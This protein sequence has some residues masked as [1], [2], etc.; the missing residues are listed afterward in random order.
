MVANI[1]VI[2]RY[3]PDKAS[4]LGPI[5][6]KVFPTLP[7]YIRRV[8]DSPYC[9]ATESDYMNIVV[10]EIE[11]AKVG[12]AVKEITKYHHQFCAIPG[13][14]WA[15]YNAIPLK[16]AMPIIGLKLSLPK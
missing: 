16:D 8:G 11:D 9:F 13:F 5:A 6:V 3:P 14:K 10:Y 4:E 1:V 7:K 2:M 15:M 12:D